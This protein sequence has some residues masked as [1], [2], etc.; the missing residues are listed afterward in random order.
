MSYQVLARKWRPK[1]FSELAG[2]EHV[3]RALT[4]AIERGRR[5]IVRRSDHE[6]KISIAQ[7]KNIR[8]SIGE[9]LRGRPFQCPAGVADS[10]Q[11]G[12]ACRLR[13]RLELID[14]LS[15]K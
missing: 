5:D 12:G 13:D 11:S 15:R 7:S 10:Q 2:Q 9:K 3:V 8:A 4:N 6:A 1:R 14:L